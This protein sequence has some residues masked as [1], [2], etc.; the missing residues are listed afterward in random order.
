MLEGK[1]IL[2]G[3]SGGIAAYKSMFLI[4][5]FKKAGAE[6]RVVA[7]ESAM[8]FVTRVT[9]ESL[10][11]NKVYDK[12]FGEENDYTT[13][14]ISL[15]DWGDIFVVAPATANIIGKYANGI[16]DDALSTSL[17]AF[18]KKVFMAP[19]MNCKMY[20]NFAFQRNLAY[21][22][23]QQVEIIEPASGYLACGYEGKGRMEE[24]EEIFEVIKSYFSQNSDF[25]GKKILITAGPTYENIDP[26]RFIGNYSSGKMGFALAEELARRGAEV[27]LVAGPVNLV[28]ENTSIERADVTNAEE[29]YNF[30]MKLF[31][32]MDAAVLTAA[33]SDFK[34]RTQHPVKMKSSDKSLHIELIPN[35]DILASLGKMKIPLQILAGFALETDNERENARKKLDKKNLDFIVL[36]S[37]KDKGAGFG[38]DTNKITILDNK[39]Q[40][41]GFEL[42]SKKQVAGD[43][44]DK[45]KTFF[46]K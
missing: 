37:L 40:V 25:K 26:V 9:I 4:R 27:K 18:D 43:I 15:T 2:L 31:P 33:V 21:L 42:K 19:A 24:P 44:A 30:C 7:T 11:Q 17:I 38:T 12:V 29:M 5:L 46:E 3:I 39:N 6:V 36:N 35:P 8:W 23:E 13:E 14:H 28:V 20:E 22:K 32:D 10:S 16:A 41:S 34:P 45:L 1:K